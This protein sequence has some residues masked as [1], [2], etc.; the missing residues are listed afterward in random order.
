MVPGGM[1]PVGTERLVVVEVPKS[2]E[3]I[4]WKSGSPKI[5]TFCELYPLFTV[6]TGELVPRFLK[7]SKKLIY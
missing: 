6:V 4:S 3:Y 5:G 1:V 7:K 2:R